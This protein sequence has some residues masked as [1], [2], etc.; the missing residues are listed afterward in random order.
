V[1]TQVVGWLV[2]NMDY[3]GVSLSNAKR[4]A[5][6]ASIHCSYHLLGAQPTNC[7]VF[8]LKHSQQ[9]KQV[10]KQVEN[11]FAC[12]Y[13]YTLRQTNIARICNLGR[14]KVDEKK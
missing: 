14:S 5:W 10:E 1:N 12:L 13:I 11:I 9:I 3:K 2:K 6:Q 8:H 4:W 7:K